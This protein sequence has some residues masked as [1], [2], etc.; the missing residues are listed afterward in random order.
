LA[1]NYLNV[2]DKIIA[3]VGA[4]CCAPLAAILPTTCH[5]VKM[6]KTNGEKLEDIVIL[7]IAFTIMT[8]T[9]IQTLTGG[10]HN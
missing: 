8:F 5:L 2:L 1:I 3:M 6:A 9:I 7:I 10:G 4:L